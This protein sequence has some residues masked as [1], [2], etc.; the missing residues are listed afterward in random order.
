MIHLLNAS[1]ANNILPFI[2]AGYAISILVV[3]IMIVLENRS[4]LKTIS[5]VLVLL[6]LPGLGFIFYIFF[7]QNFRKE[8]II[9]R[10]G[11][12]NHHRINYLAHSQITQLA[13]GHLSKNDIAR[14]PTGIV[15]LLLNNSSSVVTTGNEVTFLQNGTRK[16]DALIRELKKAEHFIHLQ[17]YIFAEDNIGN[18]VK[19]ILKEKARR[20]IEVRLIV[21]DVGS[22]ELKSPF[23]EEMRDAGIEVYSF[24]QVHFPLLT[25]KVNYRNHR[26]IVV[27][28]GHVGFIGGYNIADRY[29]DGDLNSY[30]IWRDTHIMIKGDAVNS[31]QSIFLIDWYFVSQTELSDPKYFPQSEAIGNKT[32]Q[33]VPSGPDSDWPAIMMG[34]FQ[35][36]ATARDY[37]Y[38]ATPY[39]MPSESVLLALKT[40]ALSGVD[41]RI[42]I[43]EKSDAFITLLCSRSYIRE[44]LEAGVQ[45]YFY[46]K[47]FLHSKTL[48]A[49][50][51]I[52]IVGSANMDF[53]SF[54]QN[55]EATA[56]IYDKETGIEMKETFLQDQAD[57]EI[58]LLP[59][60]MDRPFLE[61]V[62]ESFARLFSPLL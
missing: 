12:R 59:E 61:K 58:V 8:K 43:P 57:S 33:I 27:I 39:F 30:G 62:K 52:S 19:E 47:G 50:D 25:S 40:A 42:I 29:R 54:E 45:V 35:T 23:Y 17:Y 22:W 46:Q 4:P 49:D 3:V 31:L 36:I 21:D 6:L 37:V 16:F 14:Q 20:G 7:G 15:R 48:V 2:L 26:K 60:W 11:L 13:D 41:V 24:L 53:R 38:I 1:F 18:Q 34:I 55:F 32:M 56:F 28:D 51:R 44:I 10:K 5:W 9:A